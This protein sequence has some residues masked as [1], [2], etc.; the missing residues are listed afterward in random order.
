MSRL[1]CAG[2]PATA[3]QLAPALVNQGHFTSLQVR[4]GAVQGLDLH[5]RRLQAGTA[6]L[7]ATTLDERYVRQSMVGALRHA[8][9]SDASL[10]VTVFAPAF[11]F[12][13]PLARV[14]VEV[15]VAVSA[16][17]TLETPCRVRSV[18]YQREMP[19]VKHVGTFGLFQQRRAAMAAGFDDALFVDAAGCFSEGTTWNLALHD[20]QRLLWPQAPA[21]RGTAE[22]LLR[23]G[24]PQEQAQRPVA[25]AELP[26]MQ[27]ALAC[28]ASGI[29]PLSAIDGHLL[30]GSQ[31]LAR[32]GR[33]VLAQA[34]WQP[35]AD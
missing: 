13:D 3:A 15:L 20:G 14:A 2:L 1:Y 4:N 34:P 35:L 27:A 8:G 21:L 17:V 9:L 18:A 6:E 33:A 19:G 31:A 32:Q 7:F 11:D 28:N 16:P 23:S 26:Q 12:R 10:R 30:P 25:R 5:L 29:W 22:A 24:W